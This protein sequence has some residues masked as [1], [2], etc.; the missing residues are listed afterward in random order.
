[1]IRSSITIDPYVIEAVEVKEAKAK[2]AAASPTD[3]ILNPDTFKPYDDEPV[4]NLR[5][6]FRTV[7][8]EY[9]LWIRGECLSCT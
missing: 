1:M 7:M 5:G 3:D 9:N 4:A 8:K 6:R 2:E